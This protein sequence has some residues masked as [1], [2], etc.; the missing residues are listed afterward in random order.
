MPPRD[1]RHT[2]GSTMFRQRVELMLF[3]AAVVSTRRVV[4]MPHF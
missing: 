2:R 3:V 4:E 1:L